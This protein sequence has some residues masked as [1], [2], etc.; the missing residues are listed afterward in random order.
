MSRFSISMLAVDGAF[1]EYTGLT[2]LDEGVFTSCCVYFSFSANNLYTVDFFKP[3]FFMTSSNW[4]STFLWSFNNVK[5]LSKTN[6]CPFFRHYAA[7][8][9]GFSANFL[10]QWEQ[11]N[12]SQKTV[13]LMCSLVTNQLITDR[14]G[15]TQILNNNLLWGEE[16]QSNISSC[17]Y[18]G[19][20]KISVY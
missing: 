8:A 3:Y 13:S 6:P 16:S 5:L 17:K 9:V 7:L 19:A 4:K 18:Y 2:R 11:L 15:A 10:S 14:K 20:T 12:N 1:D